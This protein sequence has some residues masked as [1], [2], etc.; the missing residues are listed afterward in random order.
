MRWFAS[1][2]VLLWCASSYAQITVNPSKA[3]VGNK[4]TAVVEADVPEGAQFDGGWA[5]DG[6][7]QL[8]ELAQP[9]S[10]GIWGPAGKY[11]IT[12]SGF[13]LLLKEVTFKDG[14]G[15]EITIQSYLGHGFINESATLVLEGENGPDPQPDPDPQPVGP[16]RIVLFYDSATLDDMTRDQQAIM[17]GEQI[18]A[19]L[20]EK[21]HDLLQ[22]IEGHPT[23][24]PQELRDFVA[25]VRGKSLP[26]VAIQGFD[27]GVVYEFPLPETWQAFLNTL[28]DPRLKK[29]SK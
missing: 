4:V 18:K 23:S 24:Y 29:R 10:I 21:G 19:I 5:I 13:W 8:A 22:R 28:N 3:A 17:R 7:A 2:I 11:E 15:N 6:K 1:L 16:W 12:Y 25:A 9:N 26:R 27:G 14:D 20:K